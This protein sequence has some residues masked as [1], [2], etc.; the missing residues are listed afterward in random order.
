LV[1]A[2]VPK[3]PE[4]ENRFSPF[5]FPEKYIF[6]YNKKQQVVWAHGGDILR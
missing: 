4:K 5:V 2:L 6:I 3:V 1:P